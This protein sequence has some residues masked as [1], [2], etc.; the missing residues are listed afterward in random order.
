MRKMVTTLAAAMFILSAAPAFPQTQAEKD[1]CLLASKN[2]AD[3]V[4]DIYKRIHKLEKEVKKGTRVYS[5]QELKKLEAKLAETQDMLKMLEK[6][7][8]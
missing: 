2:C 8:H 5:P 7:G 1:E 3:Q 6:P 4:D